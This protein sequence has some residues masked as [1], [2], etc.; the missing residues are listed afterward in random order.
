MPKQMRKG[1]TGTPKAGKAGTTVSKC[2]PGGLFRPS[3]QGIS[4]HG[5]PKQINARESRDRREG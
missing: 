4:A 1:F 3:R 2:T 5:Q